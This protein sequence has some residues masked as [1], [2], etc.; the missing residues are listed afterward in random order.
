MSSM[1]DKT[2]E[3][4]HDREIAEK[5]EFFWGWGTPAG[6]LRAARRAEMI[7]DEIKKRKLSKVLEIG[8]G[9]G[10]FTEFFRE[11]GLDVHGID[12]SLDLVKKAKAKTGEAGKVN[13]VT[14]DVD[15]LPYR[16]DSFDAAVGICV[17]H[18]L[19]VES[20]LK[21]IKR[22]VKKDGII[23][24][25][26]PN[27]MN[28]QLMI[29]KNIKP[30]KRLKI[31]GETEDETA[32]FRWGMRKLLTNLGFKDISITPFDFLHPWTPESCIPFVKKLGD[33]LEKTPVLKEISGSLFILAVK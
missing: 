15:H 27:M 11:A 32:F 3:I 7:I 4:K 1:Q 8:S 10:M 9:T 2:R 29:Q 25:S 23:V 24:F 31:L 28:P 13:L 18:H 22:V 5:A 33:C 21:E 30:I 12:I 14:A 6:K 20:A 19:D 16:S 17:L 26:E